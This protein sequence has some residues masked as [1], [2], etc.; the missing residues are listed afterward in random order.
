MGGDMIASERSAEERGG[1]EVKGR[2]ASREERKA[3][4]DAR[5]DYLATALGPLA[6]K[7]RS[8]PTALQPDYVRWVVQELQDAPQLVSEARN[9]SAE[10]WAEVLAG[11][12]PPLRLR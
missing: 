8:E 12:E 4:L 2:P 3:A 9:L 1:S 11:R 10:H 5:L 7:L 6:A